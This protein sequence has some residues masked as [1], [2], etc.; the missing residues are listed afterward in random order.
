MK[1]NG[2]FEFLVGERQKLMS[3]PEP[4]HEDLARFLSSHHHLS[5]LHDVQTKAYNQVKS[6]YY[7]KYLKFVEQITYKCK[8]CAGLFNEKK[9][10]FI[11]SSIPPL[12]YC[13]K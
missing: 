2:V 8:H 13:Y 4:Q 3:I 6:N 11:G 1:M 12:N 5:W 7:L 10:Y 9:D